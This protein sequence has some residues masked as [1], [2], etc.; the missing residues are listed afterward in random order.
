MKDKFLGI[1]HY[2]E[3]NCK[4]RRTGK[5]FPFGRKSGAEIYCKNC[6]EHISKKQLSE[7]KGERRRRR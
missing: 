3:E 4:H 5:H 7:I 2:K 1:E 6:G